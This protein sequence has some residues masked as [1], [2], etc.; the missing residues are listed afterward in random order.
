MTNSDRTRGD[1]FLAWQR[2]LH[3]GQALG[4]SGR[5]VACIVGLLPGLFVVT[6]TIM[7]LRQRRRSRP[8]RAVATVTATSDR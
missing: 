1:A 7:W 2:L 3:T 8:V 5:I 6:G 4:T